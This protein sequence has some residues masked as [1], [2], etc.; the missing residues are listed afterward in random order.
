MTDADDPRSAEE[1]VLPYFFPALSLTTARP[2]LTACHRRHR[3]TVASGCTFTAARTAA[4]RAVQLEAQDLVSALK[5]DG[6]H[7]ARWDQAS[8]HTTLKP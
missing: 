6:S 7:G 2:L 1:V 5:K 4:P 8:A 3:R